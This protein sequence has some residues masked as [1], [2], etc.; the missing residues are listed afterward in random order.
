[1]LH[2]IQTIEVEDFNIQPKGDNHIFIDGY[3]GCYSDY[4]GCTSM[5]HIKGMIEVAVAGDKINYIVS[6][7][8]EHVS[9]EY[10]GVDWEDIILE[11]EDML[12]NCFRVVL[13]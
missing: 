11:L 7:D 4:E 3:V 1:M 9:S 12:R 6:E 8:L 13:E 5:E 2:L 10:D